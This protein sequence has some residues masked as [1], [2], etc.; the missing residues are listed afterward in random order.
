MLAGGDQIAESLAMLESE[1]SDGATFCSMIPKIPSI[2]G[3]SL[4]LTTSTTN[5]DWN[6]S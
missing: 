6:G 4:Q 5:L 2:T 1:S 3:T